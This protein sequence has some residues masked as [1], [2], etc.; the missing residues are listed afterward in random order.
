MGTSVRRAEHFGEKCEKMARH[1]NWVSVGFQFRSEFNNPNTW[2][3]KIRDR[4][5]TF[6]LGTQNQI[7]CM[8]YFG[9]LF[10]P[11]LPFFRLFAVG[12]VSLEIVILAVSR[13]G[14]GE[15]RT[16]CSGN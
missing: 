8:I 14:V 10:D 9:I 13:T 7:S 16:A 4:F 15:A 1:A 6:F 11:S 5:S 2:G 3:E 12:S